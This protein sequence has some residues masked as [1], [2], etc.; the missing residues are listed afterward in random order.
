MK[1]KVRPESDF[2]M[3]PFTTPPPRSSRPLST[4]GLIHIS[5]QRLMTLFQSINFEEIVIPS[6]STTGYPEDT[7]SFLEAV[8][9]AFVSTLIEHYPRHSSPKKLLETSA[10]QNQ[11]S[12]TPM[13]ATPPT[14]QL[15]SRRPI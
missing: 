3:D 14:S 5:K 11:E 2:F 15:L 12:P 13:H 8:G 4:Q 1:N 10:A 9:R 6:Q 7:I